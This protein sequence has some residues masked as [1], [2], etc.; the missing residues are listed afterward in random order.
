MRP[1]KLSDGRGL[2]LLITGNGSKLWR[3]KYRLD[4]KEKVM[5]LGA[6]PEVSI[7]QA[8]DAMSAARKRLAEGDDP[9][10]LRRAEKLARKS[11]PENPLD[12]APRSWRKHKEVVHRPRHLEAS[13]GRLDA[14]VSPAMVSPSTSS[15]SWPATPMWRTPSC[16]TRRTAPP[17]SW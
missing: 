15:G 2:Y 9:M 6:Y 14:D 17:T 16:P 3:W 11:S 4:G 10:A 12:A 5:A 1:V 7:A 8:R 13:I